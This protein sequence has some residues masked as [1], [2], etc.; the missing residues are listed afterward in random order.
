M[1]RYLYLPV[2]DPFLPFQEAESNAYTVLWIKIQFQKQGQEI[3][4]YV[5]FPFNSGFPY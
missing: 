2:Y 5:A 4:L 3:L 1:D